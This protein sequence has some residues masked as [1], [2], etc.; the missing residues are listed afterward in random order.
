MKQKWVCEV[1]CLFDPFLIAQTYYY[2]TSSHPAPAQATLRSITPPDFLLLLF[3]DSINDDRQLNRPTLQSPTFSHSSTPIPCPF[4][5]YMIIIASRN[6][7]PR[8][9]FLSFFLVFYGYLIDSALRT[10]LLAADEDDD[11]DVLFVEDS[12]PSP[13]PYSSHMFVLRRPYLLYAIIF[14]FPSKQYFWRLQLILV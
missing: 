10:P 8:V 1:V 3:P 9:C 7:G 5:H 14:G 13:P 12:S 2:Y 11:D 4:L 6:T